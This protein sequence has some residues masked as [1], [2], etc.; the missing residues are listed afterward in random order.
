METEEL[1]LPAKRRVFLLSNTQT[2]PKKQKLPS[3]TNG[4]IFRHLTFESNS[5]NVEMDMS[6]TTQDSSLG[7]HGNVSVSSRDTSSTTTHT[8]NVGSAMKGDFTPEETVTKS[9]LLPNGKREC[10]SEKIMRKK[11]MDESVNKQRKYSL[12]NVVPRND[13][14]SSHF[15]TLL[16]LK[17]SYNFFF[18]F[19]FHLPYC[20]TP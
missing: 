10:H 9:P 3:E 12:P 14:V 7:I 19:I 4:G 16:V 13:I 2:P 20:Y 15:Y 1:S 8:P 6:V 5:H 11:S 18:N 17:P